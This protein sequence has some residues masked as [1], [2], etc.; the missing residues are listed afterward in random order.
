M[1]QVIGLCKTGNTEPEQEY[2]LRLRDKENTKP[3]YL[4]TSE[5]GTEAEV[6]AMLKNGG[7]ADA[8]IDVYFGHA[9]LDA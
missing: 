4:L 1:Y 9:K 3:G 2:E 6:R 8:Q 7:M 5:Y